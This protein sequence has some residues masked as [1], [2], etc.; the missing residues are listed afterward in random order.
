MNFTG[1]KR[2]RKIIL[3][4]IPAASLQ[5]VRV[6]F[7]IEKNMN[8]GIFLQTQSWKKKKNKTT[9]TNRPPKSNQS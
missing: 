1:N 8:K 5:T 4:A 9:K 3:P 2:R 6:P 7:G